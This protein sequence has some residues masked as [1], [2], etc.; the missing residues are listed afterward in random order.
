V[1]AGARDVRAV[2]GLT[3]CGMGYC[4]GRICGPAVQAAVATAT[5]L[6]LSQ[7]GD[8]HSRPVLTPV[9]LGVIAEPA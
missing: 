4:Q 6:P 3:R 5:G 7:V 8:L 9:P 2:K 1:Q